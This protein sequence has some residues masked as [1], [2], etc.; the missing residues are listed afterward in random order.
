[1]AQEGLVNPN[2]REVVCELLKEGL[3]ARRW[4]TLTVSSPEFT[5]FLSS[6]APNV[7]K[8]LE[9][10]GD[11]TNSSSLRISLWVVCIGLAG[12]LIFTQREMFSVWVTYATGLAAAVPAVL[13]AVSVFRGKSGTEA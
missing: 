9:T 10:R 4:G 6:I 2:C 11:G 12:F 13:K 3:I 8:D 1:L 7:I 5:G